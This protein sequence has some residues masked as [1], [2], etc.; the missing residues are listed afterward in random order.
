MMGVSLLD[1]WDKNRAARRGATARKALGHLP[2]SATRSRRR[3]SF[4]FESF[5]R[6]ITVYG[7][8]RDVASIARRERAVT[9]AVRCGRGLPTTARVSQTSASKALGFFLVS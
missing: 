7:T 9:S 3:Y 2:G 5:A 8:Q 1:K 6:K 4:A